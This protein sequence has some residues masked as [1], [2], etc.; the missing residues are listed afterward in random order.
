MASPNINMRD[1]TLYR[2]RRAHHHRTGDAWCIYP[3]YDFAHP[4][5]DALERITHSLCTLEFEDHRPLYDWLDRAPARCRRRPRQ[6]EFARLNLNYTVMSKRKLLQLVQQGHVTGWDD[7]RMPTIVGLRRRGYTP[8]AI[9]DFCDA[10][11]RR[12]EGERHRRGA[13]RAQ[14]PRG[15]EPPRAARDGACCDP[16]KVVIDE[17]SRRAESKRSTSSTIPRT[18]P[19]GRARCRSRASCTS[20]ATTSGRIRRRSSSGCRPAGKC[21]CAARTSSPAPRS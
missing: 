21:G 1:P 3:M 11:R 15:S 5:S 2:I 13:A 7:P 19:P 9:R 17:L 8:E 18:R 6:I 10:H 20:S 16:L 4:L 12:Q 14:R